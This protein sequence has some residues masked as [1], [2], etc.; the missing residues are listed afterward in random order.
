MTEPATSVP[1]SPRPAPSGRAEWTNFRYLLAGQTVSLVGR[2]ITVVALPIVAVLQ[3]NASTFEVGLITGAEYVAYSVFGLFAGVYVDRWRRRSVLLW[4]D[5]ARVVVI[6]AVPVLW[7][8]DQLRLWHVIVVALLTGLFTLFFDT[9]HQAYL[10]S[11]ISR[12]KLVRGNA[13]LQTSASVAELAG[14]GIGG[15]VVQLVGAA[16]TLVGNAVTYLVSFVAVLAIRADREDPAQ[17][18]AARRAAAGGQASGETVRGQI[19]EG[20][21]YLMSDKIL[22]SFIGTIGQFNFLNTAQQALLVVFLLRV[23]EVSPAV[24]GLLMASIGAGA[25]LGALIARP[26]VERLGV[27][28]TMVLAAAIGPAVGILIPF[29]HADARLAFF[30]IGNAALGATPTILKVVGVSYRQAIVPPHLLGRVVATNRAFT[31]GPLPLGGLLGGVL[32]EVFG[33]RTALLII[34]LLF[35]TTFVWLLFTPAWHLRGF[36]DEVRT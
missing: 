34:A 5:A 36:G 26:M 33:V 1:A 3:L 31:W 7:M 10:P 28:R 32:G 11:L 29:T 14:P 8:F 16:L 12:D 18:A 20:L 6:G 24:V 13:Q 35:T 21:R 15:L 4:S 19:V 9:A 22:R 25:V 23:V 2:A 27:G 17:L 30:V